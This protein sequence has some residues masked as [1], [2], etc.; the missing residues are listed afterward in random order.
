MITDRLWQSVLQVEESAFR[1]PHSYELISEISE[2]AKDSRDNA[3]S[4]SENI[5]FLQ[6]HEDRLGLQ[7]NQFGFFYLDFDEQIEYRRKNEMGKKDILLKALG[8]KSSPFRVLDLTAGLLVDSW[9]M[10]QQGLE[11]IA[12]ERHPVVYLLIQDALLRSHKKQNIQIVFSSAT[13]Y[14]KSSDEVFSAIYFDPMFPQKEKKKSLPR[15]QM[16][17]FR[18][19]VGADEDAQDVLE[20]AVNSDERLG[21]KADRVILKRPDKSNLNEGFAESLKKRILHSYSGTSVQFD[22]YR[23]GKTI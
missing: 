3:V 21:F 15:K 11:V 7:S 23:S 4:K 22:V 16:Q 6:Y 14:L 19:L 5:F 20:L 1:C 2:L 10:S 13:Q 9:F 8:Y 17:I 12:V 18:Q